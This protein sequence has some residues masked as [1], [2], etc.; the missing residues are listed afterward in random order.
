VAYTCALRFF[1]EPLFFALCL[2][3]VFLCPVSLFAN[4]KYFSL[5]RS[6]GHELLVATITQAECP[7]ML[8]EKTA[9]H[10][11]AHAE[12]VYSASRMGIKDPQTKTICL[13][14]TAV[15]PLWPIRGN[16]QRKWAGP[17]FAHDEHP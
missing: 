8:I 11:S 7:D 2:A 10:G 5:R 14:I 15:E 13:P 17:V 4:A 6:I 12:S 3:I 1:S 16:D 9:W